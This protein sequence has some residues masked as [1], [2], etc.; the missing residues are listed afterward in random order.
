MLEIEEEERK[1]EL[2]IQKIENEFEKRMKEI[3]I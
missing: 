2:E 3:N 1:E